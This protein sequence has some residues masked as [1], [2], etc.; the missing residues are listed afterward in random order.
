MKLSWNQ[1][2]IISRWNY[3]KMKLS[4]DEII[5]KM[6]NYILKHKM[7]LP[8]DKATLI[9]LLV[10][11]CAIPLVTTQW[12]VWRQNDLQYQL[13]GICWFRLMFATECGGGGCG[14]VIDIIVKNVRSLLEKR[15]HRFQVESLNHKLL[16]QR[17]L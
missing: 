16:M 9:A 7:F 14:C 13:F 12:L 15:R 8:T 4:Q 10:R 11:D 3:L 1:D 5:L 2:E 17:N 6:K